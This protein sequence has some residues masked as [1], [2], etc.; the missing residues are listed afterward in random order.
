MAVVNKYHR[1][2]L[3]VLASIALLI[4]ASVLAIDYIAAEESLMTELDETGSRQQLLSERI[5]H[6]TLE[7]AATRDVG[8]R[9]AH[10]AKDRDFARLIQDDHEQGAEHSQSGYEDNRRDSDRRG[11]FQGPKKLQP[12]ML[13][14]L[15]RGCEVVH[16][17]LYPIRIRQSSFAIVK[18][19]LNKAYSVRLA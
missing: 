6:L 14:L 8:S 12:G 17:A 10:G 3:G 7:Y 18:T 9:V 5:V 16:H 4:A 15:P 19:Q 1:I 2:Y 13:A 11:D